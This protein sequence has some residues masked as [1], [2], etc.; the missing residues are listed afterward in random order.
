[1]IY[2]DIKNEEKSMKWKKKLYRGK[3]KDTKNEIKKHLKLFLFLI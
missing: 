1:M 3:K 2:L